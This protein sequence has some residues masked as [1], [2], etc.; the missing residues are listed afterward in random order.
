MSD[1]KEIG[2]KI[3]VGVIILLAVVALALIIYG[4]FVVSSGDEL[5][6]PLGA[7]EGDGGEDAGGIVEDGGDGTGPFGDIPG[8][9]SGGVPSGVSDA[10]DGTL[11]GTPS[12]GVGP[13]SG[14]GVGSDFEIPRLRELSD[15]PTA[16]VYAFADEG[17]IFTRFLTR[18]RGHIFEARMDDTRL[19]RVTNTTIPQIYQAMWTNSEENLVLRYL[20]NGTEQVET[21]LARIIPAEEG[22]AEGRVEGILLPQG[23]EEIAVD[24]EGGEIFYLLPQGNGVV[25]YITDINASKQKK[26][27]ESPITEWIPQWTKSGDIILTTKPSAN[28]LGHAYFLDVK[29]GELER[30]LGNEPGMT[31]L[32]NPDGTRAIVSRNTR[33]GFET[34]IYDIKEATLDPIGIKTLSEKCVWS[35]VDATIVYCGIPVSIPRGDYPDSW[36]Q[37]AIV[38]S[39]GLWRIDTELGTVK[40]L[41]SLNEVDIASL[42]ISPNDEFLYF[43][44]KRD[45]SLWSYEL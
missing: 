21:L 36:Y 17:V 6:S 9:P 8:V 11:P 15:V 10:G 25:G 24:E 35:R 29:N 7:G 20:E 2:R 39:D 43:I 34:L 19:R 37:G 23:V 32:V 22:G 38:L 40:F 44:N 12:G 33:G 18:E 27:F 28:I 42:S 14:A 31:A 26:V 16:G 41:L 5:P 30:I 45:L 3:L 13:G 4:I 1:K